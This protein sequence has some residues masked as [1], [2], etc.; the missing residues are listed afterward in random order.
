VITFTIKNRVPHKRRN[1]KV[2]RMKIIKADESHIP[3]VTEI[4][5]ELV[6]LHADIFP[7]YTRSEE[8][9]ANFE[10]YARLSIQS[11]NSLMLVALEG[12][13]VVAYS[14]SNVA[15]HPPVYLT[16][17]YGLISDMAVKS[18]HRRKGIGGE[19]LAEIKKW[20]ASLGIDRIELHATPGNTS[21]YSFW[22]KNGFVDYEHVMY[23]EEG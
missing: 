13:R 10:R 3:Q 14:V 2:I 17:T 16:E 21:G 18:G 15:K 19:M 1:K 4:W 11:D 7:F 20:F 5:K 23:L 8:G 12:D 22:K 9:P 6:D